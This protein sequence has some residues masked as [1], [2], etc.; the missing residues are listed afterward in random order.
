M[1]FFVLQKDC[2]NGKLDLAQFEKFYKQIYPKGDAKKYCQAAFMTY[3]TDN[4]GY[5][6]FDEFISVIAIL[7]SNDNKQKFNLAFDFYDTNH[8]GVIERD[9]AFKIIKVRVLS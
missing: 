1:I 3:D 5:I 4:S 2:P 6:E 7:S 9:E 8:N